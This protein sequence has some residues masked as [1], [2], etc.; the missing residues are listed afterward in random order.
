M[1]NSDLLLAEDGLA[2]YEDLLST[3]AAGFGFDVLES[4]DLI[5][6]VFADAITHYRSVQECGS[7]RIWLS[8]VMVHK[9]VSKLSSDIFASG[10]FRQHTGT[11]QTLQHMPLTL[12]AVFILQE[13]AGFNDLEVSEILNSSQYL[14]RAR[15]SKAMAFLKIYG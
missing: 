5:K 7:P 4:R 6:N 3:I 2:K 12:R 1:N 10:C 15:L 14:V 9:C 13:R 11:N 8:K